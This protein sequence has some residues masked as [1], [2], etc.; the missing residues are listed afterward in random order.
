MQAPWALVG[1]PWALV[2]SP[3]ALVGT[4]GPL[5]AGPLWAPLGPHGP[6]PNKE[7]PQ[8]S[9]RPHQGSYAPWGSGGYQTPLTFAYILDRYLYTHIVIVI[10]IV[11]GDCHSLK[12]KT[13]N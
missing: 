5:R 2:G 4:P 11:R 10:V 12:E 13:Q 6:G 8:G 7:P 9:Q 3:W 1:F